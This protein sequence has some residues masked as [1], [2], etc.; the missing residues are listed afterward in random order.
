MRSSE[1]A[2]LP[3]WSAPRRA[4]LRAGFGNDAKG[5]VTEVEV[6]E[7]DADRGVVR[8]VFKI[9]GTEQQ[10]F[11]NWQLEDGAWRLSLGAVDRID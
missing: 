8:L 5:R 6:L 3:K 2:E 9:G 1:R 11:Q 4:S 7:C 10:V